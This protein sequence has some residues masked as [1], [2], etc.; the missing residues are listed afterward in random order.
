MVGT[1]MRTHATRPF[2]LLLAAGA[3]AISTPAIGGWRLLDEQSTLSFVSVK[4]GDVAEG[5]RFEGL[6]G[7]IDDDGTV[8]IEVD[9]A[10]VDTA[11]PLRDERMREFLFEVTSFPSAR[12]EAALDPALVSR[13]RPGEI[14]VIDATISVELHGVRQAL[15]V[16]LLTARTGPDRLLVTSAEAVIL[17]AQ[18]FG[19]APGIEKL[20]ELAG[21]S[22]ISRAVPVNF[23]LV[24]ELAQRR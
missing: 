21:L 15:D 19:L 3:L 24:F 4:S 11:I 17:D 22:A 10:R 7:R 6:S 12:I 18:D 8:V 20:R 5:H 13:I 14:S 23:V 1:I 16:A 9:L 2:A